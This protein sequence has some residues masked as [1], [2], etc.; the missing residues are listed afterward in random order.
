MAPAKK[1]VE[2]TFPLKMLI[3]S[4]SGNG[5]TYFL[6]TAKGDP[7]LTPML[8]CDFE[9]GVRSIRSKVRLIALEDLGKIKPEP[10]GID[11]VRIRDVADFNHVYEIIAGDDHPY[12]TLAI[13]S[14]SELNYLNLT[15]A[16]DEAAKSDTRH[17][18]DIPEIQDYN[19]NNIQMKKLIRFFRDLEMHTIF[20]S[21]AG[22]QQDARTKLMQYRPA[23]TGKLVNEIPGLLDV[24]G[25]LAVIED[26]DEEGNAIMYRAL[27]MHPSERYMAKARVDEEAPIQLPEMYANP[28]L[29]GLLDMLDG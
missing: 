7:R 8:I 17:D 13:D 16:V 19:R 10:G 22:E 11:V 29:P 26:T 23:L 3:H 12:K 25:Y 18:P 1:D 21:I 2:Q 15:T 5:K 14:L 28:T 20:T 4:P 9:G 24:V 6:G 27:L